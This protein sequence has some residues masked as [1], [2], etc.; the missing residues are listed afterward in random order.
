MGVELPP[1][2]VMQ[3]LVTVY[4]ALADRTRAKIVY[5]LTQGERSVNDLAVL[6]GATPS[7][8]SHHLRRLRDADLV[9]FHRH[10]NQVLYT[11]DDHHIA[12]IYRETLNHLDHARYKAQLRLSSTEE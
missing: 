2:Q 7:A 11:V 9:N 12:A 8:V 4:Q 3:D 5:I 10:G 6:V 1:D